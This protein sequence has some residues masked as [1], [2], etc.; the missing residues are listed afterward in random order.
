MNRTVYSNTPPPQRPGGGPNPGSPGPPRGR[1]G[2]RGR[3]RGRGGPPRG[4]PPRGRGMP[5]RTT[6]DTPPPAP[7]A[8]PYDP[9][10]E[11]SRLHVVRELVDTE[12]T[13]SKSLNYLV[14]YF[15]L[16]VN[17]YVV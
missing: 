13:Y 6:V 16:L 10:R 9:E 2:P 15:F 5:R 8:A 12:K 14:L 7:A 1:G 3:P 17:F 4:G 11:K